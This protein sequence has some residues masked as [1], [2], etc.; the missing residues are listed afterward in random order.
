[1]RLYY[2]DQL[3]QH[4]VGIIDAGLM[5]SSW[6]YAIPP[7]A[8]A[9]RSYG[10]CK[11]SHFSDIL[12][13]PVPDL[14]V[15]SITLHTHL[16]G[17]KVRVGLFRVMRLWWSAPITQPLTRESRSWGWPPLMRCLAFIIYYPAISVDHCWSQPNMHAYTAMMGKTDYK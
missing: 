7:T 8:S 16:A 12:P 15:I 9:F 14:S 4:D 5:V 17:R 1:M 3:R 11:T 10:L 2:T 6:G 13:E